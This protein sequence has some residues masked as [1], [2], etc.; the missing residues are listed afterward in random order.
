[1]ATPIS[2]TLTGLTTGDLVCANG[3]GTPAYT[4]SLAGVTQNVSGS[5]GSG[6]IGY[7]SGS[8]RI[9][10]PGSLTI[11]QSASSGVVL[12]QF[13]ADAVWR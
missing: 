8:I 7:V 3:C 13:L 11:T 9:T 5:V 12:R 4:F 1:M 10:S 2:N 6:G